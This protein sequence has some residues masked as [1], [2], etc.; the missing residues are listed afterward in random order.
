MVEKIGISLWNI[1][2]FRA[3]SRKLFASLQKASPSTPHHIIGL[4]ETWEGPSTAIQTPP[5][6]HRLSIP[7][8]ITHHTHNRRHGGIALLIKHP[9]N[10]TVIKVH[11]LK[12]WAIF[13]ISNPQDPKLSLNTCILY[14]PP[15]LN[16]KQYEAILSELTLHLDTLEGPTIVMGDFNTRIGTLSGLQDE[17]RCP[18][19]TAFIRFCAQNT[20]TSPQFHPSNPQPTHIGTT[21]HGTPFATTVDY[22]L[23]RQLP[24]SSQS[25]KFTVLPPPAPTNHQ[26]LHLTIHTKHKLNNTQPYPGLGSHRIR[27]NVNDI[28]HSS[29]FRDA[30]NRIL[31]P[32]IFLCIL[33]W[34]EL[35]QQITTANTPHTQKQARIDELYNFTMETIIDTTANLAHGRP[36][37]TTKHKKRLNQ[38]IS[39]AAREKK[40]M[41]NPSARYGIKTPPRTSSRCT[42][43]ENSRC[44]S[45]TFLHKIKRC[46][47]DYRKAAINHTATPDPT[48]LRDLFTELYGGKYKPQI[49]IPHTSFEPSPIPD[50]ENPFTGNQFKESIGKMIKNCAKDKS[51]GL[52]QVGIDIL[53]SCPKATALLMRTMFPIFFK[54][55]VTPTWWR[56]PQVSLIYKKNDPTDPANY[57]PVALPSHMRKFYERIERRYLMSLPQLKTHYTQCGFLDNS[58]AIDCAYIIAEASEHTARQFSKEALLVLLDI[59]KAYD[60]VWRPFLWDILAKRG[61]HRHH[62]AVLMSLFENVKVELSI[63]GR[64]LGQAPCITGLMQGAVLSPF[65]FNLFLDPLLTQLS[66]LSQGAPKIAGQP[67]PSIGFA[68]DLTLISEATTPATIART[69]EQLDLC[70]QYAFDHGFRFSPSKSHFT[71]KPSFEHSIN[72]RLQDTRLEYKGTVDCLGIRFV[73]GR[74]NTTAHLDKNIAATE[75]AAL[76]IAS[77]GIFYSNIAL[78]QKTNVFKSFVRSHLEYGLKIIPITPQ[79]VARLDQTLLSTLAHVFCTTKGSW[80][81]ARLTG[82]D[83]YTSRVALLR[84]DHERK[85]ERLRTQLF[86]A[87]LFH[88]MAHK[89]HSLTSRFRLPLTKSYLTEYRRLRDLLQKTRAAQARREIQEKMERARTQVVI[90]AWQPLMKR[91]KNVNALTNDPRLAHPM[92]RIK[93]SGLTFMLPR[94]I[95]GIWPPARLQCGTCIPPRPIGREHLRICTN[96][97]QLIM[98]YVNAITTQPKSLPTSPYER[99]TTLFNPIPADAQHFAIYH[100]LALLPSQMEWKATS[101]RHHHYTSINLLA[102]LRRWCVRARACI[103]EATPLPPQSSARRPPHS[104]NPPAIA[105]ASPP[106]RQLWPHN[107]QSS[108]QNLRTPLNTPLRHHPP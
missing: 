84:A 50:Q 87:K 99:S 59:I 42:W 62:I 4:T 91:S 66:T 23:Y 105:P 93:D 76:A 65:L 11:H 80:A 40:T 88:Q 41:P 26:L 14:A 2:G 83:T 47:L 64:Q 35:D 6:W 49:D 55:A 54:H 73:H 21:T 71:A 78:T 43:S 3:K 69:Q 31:K 48:A 9:L 5:T 106:A 22:I 57:R 86:S 85:T 51:V 60:S 46:L 13:H 72:L 30:M 10:A 16:L 101:K 92:T 102:A 100:A 17:L 18:R 45:S 89:T 27:W 28:R 63:N 33:L 34:K 24:Q 29:S 12:H 79:H 38:L 107:L 36:I 20:L 37:R 56:I 8:T 1:E 44:K 19:A 98:P 81:Q 70:T 103:R 58:G 68:D 39:K 7:R 90:K 77:L 96:A 61:L 82:C 95:T 74:I 25:P 52:D 67:I 15:S 32:F 108:P 75:A 97:E 94:L 104:H 53:S